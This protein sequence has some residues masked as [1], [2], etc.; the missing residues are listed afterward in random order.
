MVKRLSVLVDC[1][2]L[3]FVIMAVNKVKKHNCMII[4]IEKQ[5]KS[6]NFL[7]V[8]FFRVVVIKNFLGIKENYYS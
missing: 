7:E 3:V 6:R 5:I 4:K 1:F 8:V 2:S